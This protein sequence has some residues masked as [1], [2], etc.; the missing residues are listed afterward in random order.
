M[1]IYPDDRNL[2]TLEVWFRQHWEWFGG[3]FWLPYLLYKGKDLA[4]WWETKK[5]QALIG[6]GIGLLLIILAIGYIKKPTII[7]KK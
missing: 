5:W 7:I 6:T 3:L 2:A 1:S 4:K